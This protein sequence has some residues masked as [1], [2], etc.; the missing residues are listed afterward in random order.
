MYDFQIISTCNVINK[1]LNAYANEFERRIWKPIDD[2]YLIFQELIETV[3][4]QRRLND[5]DMLRI[6]ISCNELPHN[7]S[8]KF[9]KV[10]NFKLS[11]LEKNYKY[12]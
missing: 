11:V 3:K 8:T 4:K 9:M 2:I 6:V 1:K 12:S 7:I 10:K 5:N